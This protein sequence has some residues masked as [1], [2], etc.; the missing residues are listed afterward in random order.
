M[1]KILVD[2]VLPWLAMLILLI[3]MMMIKMTKL[4]TTIS[5]QMIN[6]FFLL[7]IC[8]LLNR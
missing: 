8:L 7:K 4:I 2:D 6:R 1:S 5:I 3:K